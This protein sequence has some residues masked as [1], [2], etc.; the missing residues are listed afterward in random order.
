MEVAIGLVLAL[1][2]RLLLLLLRSVGR[3]GLEVL[4]LLLMVLG[5]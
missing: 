4:G 2:G 5:R 1:V 3:H